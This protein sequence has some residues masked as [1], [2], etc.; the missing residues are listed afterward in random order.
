MNTQLQDNYESLLLAYAAGA[1]D[2][3]QSF[4][5]AV[6][7]ALSPRARN[8]VHNCE[9]LGAAM[10]ECCEPEQMKSSSLDNVLGRLDR[11]YRAEERKA[12]V[13]LP[14]D[15]R[16]PVH[17]LECITCR[18][19]QPHWRPMIPGLRIMEL[20]LECRRSQ[21]RFMKARPAARMP[22]HTH[23]GMEITLVLDGAY[24][25]DT[26]TYRRGDLLVIDD[27][28]AHGARVCREKGAVAM[29]VTSGPI[30]LTGLA[31]LL[32]PFL[33]F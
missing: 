5:V 4:A 8:F 25:D 27:D 6:H 2:Q 28:R 17:L 24:M 13:R 29:M 1:L 9:A 14:E 18:P 16:I 22:A 21:V 30:R 10:M 32:N 23:E 20:P 7:L 33:R 19:C 15:V 12:S 31:S 26:G 11:P 3:A